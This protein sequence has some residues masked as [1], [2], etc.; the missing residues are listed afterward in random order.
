MRIGFDF[1]RTKLNMDTLY[2]STPTWGNHKGI[3]KALGYNVK[4][5]RYWDDA[6]RRLDM[7]GMLEDLKVI[8]SQV[9]CIFHKC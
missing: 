1:C 3:A 4:E 7:E 2:V 9:F 6:G 5:Y 8:I